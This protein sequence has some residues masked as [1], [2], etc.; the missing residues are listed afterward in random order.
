MGLFDRFRKSVIETEEKQDL[1]ADEDSPEAR[2][3]IAEREAMAQEAA[4]RARESPPAPQAAESQWDEPVEDAEDP[5]A[6]PATAKER[7]IAERRRATRT[8]EQPAIAPRDELQS[9][10][11]RELVGASRPAFTVDLGEDSKARGG[12]VI[13]AGKALDAILEE[14]EIELMSADMGHAAVT[15]LI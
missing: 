8:A 10:T 12:R 14:L 1:T 13:K 6:A 2:E 3:A 7:K 4:G 11:G 15:E 5:F 9:T